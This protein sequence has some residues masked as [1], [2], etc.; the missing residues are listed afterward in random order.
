[1]DDLTPPDL[2]ELQHQWLIQQDLENQ[3]Y[4]AIC[5]VIANTHRNEKNKPEPFK[6][7]DFFPSLIKASE[8]EPAPEESPEILADVMDDF[9]VQLRSATRQKQAHKQS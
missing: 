5:S 1:M 8:P 4:G 7:T 3:R 9:W 2:D 6:P